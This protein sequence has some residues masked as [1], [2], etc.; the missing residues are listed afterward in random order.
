[1]EDARPRKLKLFER[2][3]IRWC[4][5]GETLPCGCLVA[6]Y[7]EWSGEI[8]TIVDAP[9]D[10]CRNRDHHADVVLADEPAPAWDSPELPMP[11]D[12]GRDRGAR[13]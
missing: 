11:D 2:F 12:A 8:L 7:E 1:M 10:T 6:R 13:R 4:L 5:Q 9:A 3:R